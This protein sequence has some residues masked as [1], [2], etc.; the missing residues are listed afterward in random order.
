MAAWM[1]H[2][3]IRAA[4][5][6]GGGGHAH[7]AAGHLQ[8]IQREEFTRLVEFIRHQGFQVGVGD[9]FLL[10]SQVFEAQEGFA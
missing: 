10:V 3:S 1:M 2:L 8:T 6:H 5:A 9:G 4:Q 7:R